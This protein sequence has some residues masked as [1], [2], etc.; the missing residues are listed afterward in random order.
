MMKPAYQALAIFMTT[1]LILSAVIAGGSMSGIATTAT[2][3]GTSPQ[4]GLLEQESSQVNPQSQVVDVTAPN[5]GEVSYDGEGSPSDPFL[6]RSVDQLQCINNDEQDTR[7]SD[8]PGL[9]DNYRLTTDLDAGE[10]GT[11]GLGSDRLEDLMR[12]SPG[13]LMVIITQFRD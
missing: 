8:R 12:D 13:R 4:L 5:C 1:V 7:R 11:M 3:G 9:D 2:T 10:S 6:I